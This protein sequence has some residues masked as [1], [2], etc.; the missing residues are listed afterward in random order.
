MKR[1]I[2]LFGVFLLSLN[3]VHAQQGF[4]TIDNDPFSQSRLILKKDTT[5]IPLK[6]YLNIVKQ[7]PNILKGWIKK[8]TKV[9][10]R[11]QRTAYKPYSKEEI[12]NW[13]N[14]VIRNKNFQKAFYYLFIDREVFKTKS[15]LIRLP[16]FEKGFKYLSKAILETKN[17][18]ASYIGAELLYYGFDNYNNPVFNKYAHLFAEPLYQT[19]KSC[20]GFYVYGR[21]FFYPP[22]QNIEKAHEIL[23]NGYKKCAFLEKRKDFSRTI[24]VDLRYDSAKA[25]GILVMEKNK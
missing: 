17:P 25:K 9:L 2:F 5:K 3:V 24:A 18:I 13:L 8:K 14:K 19:G 23:F 15:N 16:N 4:F 6:T 1:K 21:S 10:Q 12:E 11:M 22:Y 20:L 7:N